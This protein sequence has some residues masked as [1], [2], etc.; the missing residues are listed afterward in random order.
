MSKPT[1]KFMSGDRTDGY[2]YIAIGNFVLCAN[3]HPDFP[4][5]FPETTAGERQAKA[6]LRKRLKPRKTR[7]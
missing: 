6:Y 1:V 4:I 2:Y 3:G 7:K 5:C